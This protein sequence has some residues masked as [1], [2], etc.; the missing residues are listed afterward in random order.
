[1]NTSSLVQQ[2]EIDFTIS[3]DM[4]SEIFFTTSLAIN[5]L[6]Q[7][8][9]LVMSLSLIV[10]ILLHRPLRTISNLCV[11]NSAASIFHF[12]LFSLCQM[13]LGLWL[14]ESQPP[15]LCQFLA[16]MTFTGANTICYSYL[17]TAI[18]QYFF[19]VLHR[20]NYLLKFNVHCFIIL[21]N[22]IICLLLPLIL[23][24]LGN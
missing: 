21:I 13:F 5:G 18:S 14:A 4:P 9:N 8:F 16:Y 11:A 10:P 6:L 22:W 7:I 24:F 2:I 3:I 20:Y 17:V 23:Y 1:M 12:G 15:T 19:N